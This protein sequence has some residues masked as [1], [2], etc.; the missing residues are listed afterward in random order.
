MGK[1]RP[2]ARE[3]HVQGR[4]T[5]HGKHGV[6]ALWPS[7]VGC[8]DSFHEAAT[9]AAAGVARVA[10]GSAA[11]CVHKALGGCCAACVRRRSL[12]RSM[13]ASISSACASSSRSNA[14][15]GMAV[16]AESCQGGDNTRDGRPRAQIRGRANNRGMVGSAGTCQPA[17]ATR[18]SQARRRARPAYD[19]EGGKGTPACATPR[20]ASWGHPRVIRCRAQPS[21]LKYV[22]EPLR[23][24]GSSSRAPV[25]LPPAETGSTAAPPPV[26]RKSKEL[27]RVRGSSYLSPDPN[28]NPNPNPRTLTNTW[29]L[30]GRRMVEE[31]QALE[32]PSVLVEDR[33]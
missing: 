14:L 1:R 19:A 8:D 33:A 3:R 12:M 26:R 28:P 25:R 13:L 9:P 10:A 11:A 16:C 21:L 17:A 30:P 7:C 20:P 2:S 6:A 24:V 29:P 18:R 5:R 15:D 32:G 23:N 4:C 27:V 22:F 31:A